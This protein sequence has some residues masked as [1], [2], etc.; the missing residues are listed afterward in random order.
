MNHSDPENDEDPGGA[1]GE[2]DAHVHGEEGGVG[3][4]EGEGQGVGD[5][6]QELHQHQHRTLGGA[7]HHAFGELPFALLEMRAMLFCVNS[8]VHRKVV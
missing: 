7:V 5:R 6:A 3:H 2:E 8:K 4:V 1:E